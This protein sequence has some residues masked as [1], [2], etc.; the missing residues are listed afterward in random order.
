MNILLYAKISRLH[1]AFCSAKSPGKFASVQ[2]SGDTAI[3]FYQHASHVAYS[4]VTCTKLVDLLEKD[5]IAEQVKL[6]DPSNVM[7]VITHTS[8]VINNVN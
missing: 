2:E 6:L 8:M 4:S 5:G 3:Y 7:Q 1:V